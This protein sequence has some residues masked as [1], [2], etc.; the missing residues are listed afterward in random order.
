MAA[1]RLLALRDNL[2]DALAGMSR[3]EGYQLDYGPVRTGGVDAAFDDASDPKWRP[4]VFVVWDGETEQ[5]AVAGGEMATGRIRHF[6][7]FSVVVPIVSEDKDHDARAWQAEQDIHRALIYGDSRA[8]G[9]SGRSTT[10]HQ[11]TNW[12]GNDNGG[13]LECVF[14][15]RW[16]HVS[17]DMTTE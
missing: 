2:V 1:H 11:K 13:L 6:S 5:D 10:W 4:P 17:G 16:D 7:V 8:R 14:V 9:S 15:V 12:A 3:A